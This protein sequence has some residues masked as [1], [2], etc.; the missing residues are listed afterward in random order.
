[1]AKKNG[2]VVILINE[3]GKIILTTKNKDMG[4]MRLCVL[5]I[6]FS[7]FSFVAS[8]NILNLFLYNVSFQYQNRDVQITL[9]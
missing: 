5:Y 8:T 1:M 9:L 2:Q 6:D 3:Y 7:S 4:V